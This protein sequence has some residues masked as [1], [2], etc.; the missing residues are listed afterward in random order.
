MRIMHFI[1]K[2][3]ILYLTEKETHK[4]ASKLFKAFRDCIGALVPHKVSLVITLL[5]YITCP[6]FFACST[7]SFFHL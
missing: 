1:T 3:H 4:I 5:I 7:K 6:F 2:I